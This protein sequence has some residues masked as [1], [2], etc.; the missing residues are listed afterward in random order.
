MN[1]DKFLIVM[2]VVLSSLFSFNINPGVGLLI[3]G[4]GILNTKVVES[5]ISLSLS[6]DS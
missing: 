5:S 4:K 2:N 1:D 3:R 6:L